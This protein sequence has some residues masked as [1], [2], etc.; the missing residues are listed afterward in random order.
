MARKSKITLPSQVFVAIG[1]VVVGFLAAS[2]FYNSTPSVKL[3]STAISEQLTECSE[4]A[5]MRMSYRG[6]VTYEE[7]EISLINKKGFTMVYNAEARAG[8]DL[9]QAEVTLNGTEIDV[10]LPHS[11]VQSLSI[12][13]DSLEFYDVERALFNWQ[14]REDTATALQMAEKDAQS[15]VD[16]SSMLSDADDQAVKTVQG[17]MAPFTAN[18]TYTLSVTFKD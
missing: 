10:K 9:S 12:D 1:L 11:T 2:W 15:K 4:L 17:L 8:V 16:E 5:T 3:T 7:G 14:N 6:M 18:D 13:S